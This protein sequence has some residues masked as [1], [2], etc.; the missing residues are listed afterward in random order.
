MRKTSLAV[1]AV[2]FTVAAHAQSNEATPPTS[3]MKAPDAFARMSADQA[4]ESEAYT[5]GVQAVLWGM[6]WVKAGQSFRLFSRPLPGGQERSPYD[7]LPHGVNVWGHAQRLLNSNTRLIETPNTET[8]YSIILVDLKEGPVVIVHPDF[9]DRYF[10]TSIWDLHSDTHTIS[11][12]QDGGKPSPYVVV[13][14]GWSGEIPAGLKRID[15]RSRYVQFAPHIAVT[16]QDDL[17]KVHVLQSGLKMI[18]LKDWGK[19]NA[20]LQPGQPMR[21][22]RRPGTT[23]PDEL[24]FFEELGETLKDLTVRDDETGFARQLQ[25]IGI[26]AKE[27]F[28]FDKLDAPTVAGLKRAVLDG[29]TLAAHKA[30]DLFPLQPGGTWA[31]GYDQTSLDNWLD[32]AGTGFGYVWG[33]LASEILFPQ[34]RADAAGQPLNGSNKYV[35]HFP[36]GQLPPARYWRI[37]MYDIEGFFA[38]NPINRYGIGNMAEKLESEAD[39]GLTIAIQH[40]PP[41]KDKQA[42]WLPAP[43]E[44]FFMVMRLYQPEERMYRGEYIVPSVQKVR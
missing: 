19:T 17:A 9:G 44:G 37:S 33:D 15:V 26:T 31:V 18:A 35:L 36:P 7:P 1:F 24:L 13:P 42:N 29:Q 8:L 40:D 20:E 22:I 23:T 6:Q 3:L 4:R 5:L 2:I 43:A 34:V 28:Q 11:Q 32:R 30:R 10:R 38:N 16:G 41:S 14:V 12:K 21:P 39:G 25:A 27:G